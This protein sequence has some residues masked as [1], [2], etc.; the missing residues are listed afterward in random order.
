MESP[1]GQLNFGNHPNKELQNEWNEYG[2]ES[3]EYEILSEIREKDAEERDYKK[4][5]KD[6]EELYIEEMQSFGEKGYNK[7]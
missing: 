4:E 7:K 2:E 3:F 6:L 1:K 5:I